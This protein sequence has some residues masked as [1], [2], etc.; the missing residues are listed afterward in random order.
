MREQRWQSLRFLSHP[1]LAPIRSDDFW[2]DPKKDSR[3]ENNTLR[4]EAWTLNMGP[5]AFEGN[6]RDPFRF[7]RAY[8]VE[9]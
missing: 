7:F 2:R 9:G 1:E 5:W 3:F 6:S 4:V 8:M